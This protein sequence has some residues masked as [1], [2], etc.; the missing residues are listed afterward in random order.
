MGIEVLRRRS[1]Q[2]L[3]AIAAAA[4]LHAPPATADEVARAAVR[5]AVR[6]AGVAYAELERKEIEKLTLA[7]NEVASDESLVTLFVSHEREQLLAA[8]RPTFER[9][10]SD[11]GITHWY[12]HEREPARTCFLRVHAPAVHGDMIERP[13]LS[14]AIATHRI[15]SGKELGKTAFALRVVRPLMLR[16]HLVGYVELGEEIDHF[17]TRMRAQTGDDFAL[18]VDK[19]LVDRRELAR[20][21]REDRWD[22]RADVVLI[23]ST[24]WDDKHVDLGGPLAKMT[25]DGTV[26][27][28]WRDGSASFAG[29]AFPVRD[30]EQ[31]VVGA[32]FVRHRLS[33]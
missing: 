7:L 14:Q 25:D 5:A 30:A 1:V 23:D 10:K 13:T 16:G 15:A 21:R 29:G 32:I 8:A 20:V 31:R 27:R 26:A 12:F 9:L 17:L 22:E 28:E 11:G 2:A 18:L 6:R 4:L 33:P 24:M 19:S 3:A